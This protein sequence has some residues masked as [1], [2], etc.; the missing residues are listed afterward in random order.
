MVE[1][2]LRG[3]LLKPQAPLSFE[4]R[5]QKAFPGSEWVV[6][7]VITPAPAPEDVAEEQAALTVQASA[8]AVIGGANFD[9]ASLVAW[10]RT[11][12]RDTH[13][14]CRAGRF[15]KDGEP[16]ANSCEGHLI[17]HAKELKLRIDTVELRKDLW[18]EYA[19]RVQIGDV[20]RVTGGDVYLIGGGGGPKA[21]QAIDKGD[22]A[23]RKA[24]L[25]DRAVVEVA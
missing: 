9:E 5:L 20:L 22:W 2:V 1:G 10:L 23:I 4:E 16:Y 6:E 11:L 25:G 15:T 24:T 8:I 21:V 3:Q 18:C 13:L 17:K 19:E 12:P 14:V 7:D